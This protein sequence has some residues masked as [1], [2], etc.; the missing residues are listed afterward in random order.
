MATTQKCTSIAYTYNEPLINLNYVEDTARLAQES[1]IRNVLVTNGYISIP[2]LERVVT[3]I[4][5][6]NVDWKGFNQEIYKKYCSAD[7]QSVLKATEYMKHQG[8]HVEITYLIIPEINDGEE[9]IREMTR[10]LVDQIGLETPLHLSRFFPK[11]KF[12][13]IPPTPLST[14]MRAREISIEEGIRYVFIGNLSDG[15]YEDTICPKC[16]KSVV[17]RRGYFITGWHLDNEMKCNYCDKK[18]PIIGHREN[19]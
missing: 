17:E 11:Y 15:S 14:L 3:F 16:N 2:A 7:L 6:A 4:D 13:H 19:H 12:K 1:R 8:V 9:E 5:A 10:F 18:I